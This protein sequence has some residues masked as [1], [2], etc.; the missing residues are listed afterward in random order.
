MVAA[1]I[2][3]YARPL[4][5]NRDLLLVFAVIGILLAILL[6]LPPLLMDGLLALNITFSLLILLTS[7]YM[8]SPLDFSVF[9]SVLLVMTL[10]R[11]ALNI[12]TTRL[13]LG[14]AK[15]SGALAAGQV[16][17]VFGKVVTAG[18][19][20]VGFVIFV[21]II[22]IQFVVITKGA[23][24]IAEVAARFTLDKMPGQQLSIDADL[25]AGLIDEQTAKERRERI[26]QEADFYGAMDGASKFVRGD[27]IAGILITLINII[28]GLVI[29]MASYGMGFTKA[30]EV[31]TTL[32]IGDGLVSQVPALVV[33]V[34]AALIVTRQ[35]GESNLGADLVN[36]IF[37]SPRAVGITAVFLLLLMPLGLPPLFLVLGA[38]V[39]GG[40]AY[41][42]TR[43]EATI[44][45]RAEESEAEDQATRAEPTEV[46]LPPV[47]PLELEVGYGLVNLVETG[48]RGGLLQ[49]I[50]SIR[51]QI[52]SELGIVIP[53]VRI[54]DNMQFRPSDYAIKMR[55]E[56]VASGS[57]KVDH[58]LAMDSGLGLDA[59]EGTPTKEPAFG[60]DAIWIDE[61][62]KGRAEAM[63]YTV[64]DLVSVLATHLTE[65][66]RD[67]AAELLT[68][69]EAS[70]LIDKL[71]ETSRAVVDEVIP[72]QLKLGDVQKVLQNLLREKVS[73][74][75]LESILESLAD[76]APR[77]K[78]PEVLTEYARH[79][80]SRAICRQYADD[81]GRVHVVTLDPRV[82]EFVENG[83]EHTERGSF[84]RLS[85]EMIAPIVQSVSRVLENL[86]EQGHPPVVLTS[87]QIRLQARRLLETQIP[88]VVCLS[89]NEVA[90]GVA[91][92]SLGVATV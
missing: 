17:Q 29:G 83:I 34:A 78:D 89:Y 28:G 13:I 47:D 90:R 5:A 79:A 15:D 4:G 45:S 33:S 35:T 21:V 11:L 70:R 30:V 62:T 40:L 44:A 57:L 22:V 66:I 48:D 63:G 65:V 73:I 85:P 1:T 82:E 37:S 32:T 31:F 60:I 54:R 8:R 23:T 14:N 38:V 71:K 25:N 41:I 20:V 18:N 67:H 81:S 42:M 58:Y 53:P 9:P 7:I 43:Q 74:R 92:E 75:D 39:L 88:G 24:R 91:V 52:A 68:R 69:E 26:N 84:L 3:R 51:E 56:T 36:Q 50:S 87:P 12:A 80:L 64:V 76:W 86:L 59:I 6:P 27:A 16:I 72:D 10:Y 77:T 46:T 55:G 19:P 49:R 2:E 61:E